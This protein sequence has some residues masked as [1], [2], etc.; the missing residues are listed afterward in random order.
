MS[1]KTSIRAEVVADIVI[2]ASV[3]GSDIK[4]VDWCLY[5]LVRLEETKLCVSYA[6][7]RHI[8]ES[9]APGIVHCEGK[10]AEKPACCST[11]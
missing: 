4:W 5:I 10:P 8:V 7:I 2:S 9:V 11:G 3:V 6:A 1:V